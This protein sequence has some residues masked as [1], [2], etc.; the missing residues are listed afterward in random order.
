MVVS[1]RN[2]SGFAPNILRTKSSGGYCAKTRRQPTKEWSAMRGR[3]EVGP[4]GHRG[5]RLVVSL[6]PKNQIP[7]E[8]LATVVRR[9]LQP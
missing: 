1:F 2:T 4:P 5:S 9:G 7:F 8:D 6:S 3:V